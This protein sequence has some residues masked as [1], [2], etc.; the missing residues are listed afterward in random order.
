MDKSHCHTLEQ[1]LNYTFHNRQLLS[2]ALTH[3]S[4]RQKDHNERLEFLGDA[5]L[6]LCMTQLLFKRY[7]EL[8]E[9]QLSQMRAQLVCRQQLS[10]LADRFHLTKFI[11]IGNSEKKKKN[12]PTAITANAVEAI[13][14][15]IWL[16]SQNYALCEQ[17]IN[18]WLRTDIDKLNTT[19]KYRDNKSQL[20]EWCQARQ[21]TLPTYQT[22]EHKQDKHGISRFTVSCHIT[23]PLSTHIGIGASKQAA[24]QQAAGQLLQQLKNRE[25]HD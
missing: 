18:D 14:G 8:N 12:L 15:A 6:S 25:S 24:E 22:I 21:Q 13:I 16:D 20:Q 3:R 1:L 2:L 4:T 17:L 11:Y 9:G 7:P 19:E 10:V 23:T 5:V